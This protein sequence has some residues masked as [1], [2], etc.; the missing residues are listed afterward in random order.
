[1]VQPETL[2]VPPTRTVPPTSEQ[3]AER[4]PQSTESKTQLGVLVLDA[5]PL[6][7]G[8]RHPRPAVSEEGLLDNERVVGGQV[9]IVLTVVHK[10]V[11]EQLF[12]LADGTYIII[13]VVNHHHHRGQPSSSSS[14]LS[15]SSSISS[16]Y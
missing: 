11:G 1:M 16:S 13:V 10:F 8:D 5:V 6:V 15:L 4:T 14:S 7:D 3:Q 12:A 2:S 9:H